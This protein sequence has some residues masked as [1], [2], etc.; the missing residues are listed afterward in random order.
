MKR[1]IVRYRI[2]PD[3]V[4]ENVRLIGAVF[5]ELK[6]KRP[7]GLIYA[8]FLMEDGVS[9]AHVVSMESPNGSNPLGS[10]GS[11]KQFQKD[12]PSRC[13]EA[14]VPLQMSEIASYN[15]FVP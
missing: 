14:P 11:F 12:L 7:E 9:F 13:A 15:F 5:E 4:A 1:I 10:M 3:Q 2:K 6:E 8:A